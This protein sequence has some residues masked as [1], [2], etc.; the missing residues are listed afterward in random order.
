M[1]LESSADLVLRL[2]NTMLTQHWKG[3]W[4]VRVVRQDRMY[5]Y[6]VPPAHDFG[7]GMGFH[8]AE[9]RSRVYCSTDPEYCTSLQMYLNF[10]D[11]VTLSR[12]G[13]RLGCD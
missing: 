13:L 7:T 11:F 1:R 3:R 8:R 2:P 12:F 6:E 4:T 10:C 9:P 5:L